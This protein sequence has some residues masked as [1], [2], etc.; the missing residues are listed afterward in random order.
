M[1]ILIVDKL[2]TWTLEQFLEFFVVVSV[3]DSA[4]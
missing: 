2:D 3:I 1:G 4:S